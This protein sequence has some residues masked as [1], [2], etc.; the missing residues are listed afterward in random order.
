[1]PTDLLTELM[2]KA[3]ALPADKLRQVVGYV[4]GLAADPPADA[5]HPPLVYLQPG[6]LAD[7]RYS[8]PLEDFQQLRREMWAN[9]PRE[10]PPGEGEG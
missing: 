4:D 6:C 7:E 5:G 1:M 9:F 10:F 8:L 2:A 3:S